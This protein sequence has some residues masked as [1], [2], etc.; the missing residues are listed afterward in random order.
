MKAETT[1]KEMKFGSKPQTPTAKRK[2]PAPTSNDR[3]AKVRKIGMSPL[4]KSIT[5]KAPARKGGPVKRNLRSKK[6]NVTPSCGTTPASSRG[7]SRNVSGNDH[8]LFS[9]GSYADFQVTKQ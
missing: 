3:A 5:P 4:V 6:E 7:P 2:A 8:S 9:A 1:M